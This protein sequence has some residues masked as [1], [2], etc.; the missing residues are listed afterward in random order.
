MIPQVPTVLCSMSLFL[1]VKAVEVLI[2]LRRV[3]SYFIWPFE[4]WFILNLL[5]NLTDWL[6]EHYINRLDVLVDLDCPV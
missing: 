6:S 2:A 4:E 5:Q 3:S 1:M